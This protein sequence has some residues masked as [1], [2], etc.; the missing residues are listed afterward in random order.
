MEEHGESAAHWG[1]G[2]LVKVTLPDGQ[3][4]R[5]VVIR[6]RR[7]RSGTWWYGCELTLPGRVDTARGPVQQPHVVELSTSGE[8]AY[9]DRAAHRGR[10]LRRSR[11]FAAGEARPL[12]RR[13]DAGRAASG[14]PPGL[15]RRVG[16]R[17]PGHRRGCPA[18]LGAG[19][20]S[21]HHVRD[22]SAEG[23]TAYAACACGRLVLT[24]GRTRGLR[25]AG[26]A[27]VREAPFPRYG[28]LRLR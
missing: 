9:F 21:G 25:E 8:G 15:R 12:A 20:G 2:P 23:G 14:A 6:R 18:P 4:V 22:L 11:S 17:Q 1:D 27:A 13:C 16:G 7:D 5:A 19:S 10:R 28:G 3:T 24:A 26:G